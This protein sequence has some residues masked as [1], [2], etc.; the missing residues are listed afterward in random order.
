MRRE[1]GPSQKCI[2][3]SPRCRSPAGCRPEVEGTAG[4]RTAG[5]GRTVV[6]RGSNLLT[7]RE[8][9]AVL[10][11]S[12]FGRDHRSVGRESSMAVV[13]KEYGGQRSRGRRA[14]G[15]W[16]E[17]AASRNPRRRLC[18]RRGAARPPLGNRGSKG[19]KGGVLIFGGSFN[20]TLLLY[21][22]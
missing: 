3:G 20:S 19:G 10:K 2:P 17:L 6:S 22:Y 14:N 21:Q 9:E 5:H 11:G 18:V 7:A 13:G 15:R 16:R 12:D 4:E 1:W 8:A